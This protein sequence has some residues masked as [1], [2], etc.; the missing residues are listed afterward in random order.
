MADHDEAVKILGDP[1]I[2]ELPELVQK[3][4]RN[5]LISSSF[6]LIYYFADIRI[7]RTAPLGIE[8]SGL[9]QTVIDV[10]LLALVFYNLL[11]FLWH[12]IDYIGLWRIHLTGTNVLFGTSTF[13]GSKNGD[14][15]SD[16]RRS[17]LYMW[18]QE[19]APLIGNL[20]QTAKI[21]EETAS[22]LGTAAAK[23][24]PLSEGL[25]AKFFSEHAA[26][27]AKQV[28]EVDTRLYHLENILKSSRI[29][30]SLER[31]DRW[32]RN[33]KRS[34]ILRLL[35]MEFGLPCMLAIVPLIGI[36]VRLARGALS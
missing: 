27:L 17:N 30:V 5:L 18:W 7:E 9:S 23:Y 14:Y 10:C 34:Q 25:S 8:I 26:T 6:A 19:Q 3:L 29:T 22:Q 2:D 4:R 35:V 21:L 31:F 28:T 12:C 16:P 24:E 13:L 20:S 15:P 1:V 11:H 33:F 36:S 32:F